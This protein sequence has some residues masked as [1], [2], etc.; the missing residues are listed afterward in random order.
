[1]DIFC[2]GLYG[3]GTIGLFQVL[4]GM[5]LQLP[6][7]SVH[8]AIQRHY[9]RLRSLAARRAATTKQP[10]QRCTSETRGEQA[11][12]AG[13][14]SRGDRF[15]GGSWSDCGWARGSIEWHGQG[16]SDGDVVD[17]GTPGHSSQPLSFCAKAGCY[18]LQER[19]PTCPTIHSPFQ[20][21]GYRTQYC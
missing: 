7:A 6:G 3:W 17:A 8:Q 12:I 15:R 2:W 20:E 18:Q 9:S 1:M 14:R 16:D 13:R 21:L 4:P 5:S 19:S 10:W 11:P